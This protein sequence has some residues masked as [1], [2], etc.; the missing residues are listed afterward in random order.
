MTLGLTACSS[1][2]ASDAASTEAAGDAAV[3][4]ESA[5]E[6]PEE[7]LYWAGTLSDGRV[8]YNMFDM[9]GGNAI[10]YIAKPDGSDPE[11][12]SGK[13]MT[14]GDLEVS[15]VGV[16]D[17][18]AV[19]FTVIDIPDDM[20]SLKINVSGHGIAE[21]EPITEAEFTA[22]TEQVFADETLY[23]EGTLPDGSV[24]YNM[25]D[26][27]SG[28]AV[29]YI[30]KPDG[31]QEEYY[32]GKVT[33]DGDKVTVTSDVPME[34]ITFT[35]VNKADDASSMKIDI[36]GY[37]EA[38]LKPITEADF[39]AAIDETVTGNRR[40]WKGTLPDG[41][42]VYNMIDAAEDYAILSITKPD[43]SDDK[44]YEGKVTIGGE[45]FILI[46]DKTKQSISYS[47]A[48]IPD[49]T[50]SLKINIAGYGEAELELIDE[51]EFTELTTK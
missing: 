34:T 11:V 42:A 5:A 16:T 8:I 44:Y 51:A 27:A 45:R 36:E 35:R 14:N 19:T 9:E 40:Y 12:Y 21:L 48:V 28:N 18:N 10:L 6:A 22:A 24:V 47:V 31:T 49:D 23:W 15:I 30:A 20:S 38:D 50:D 33:I 32:A 3:S 39:T 29:I 17:N 1:Q 13:M 41:R 26:M 46:D 43:G 37:G 7:V 4:G 2:Q 25:F